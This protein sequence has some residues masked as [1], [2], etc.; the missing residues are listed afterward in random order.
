[1][2]YGQG[3]F[4]QFNTVLIPEL[5]EQG[6]MTT[7]LH[8]NHSEDHSEL[9]STY[10]DGAA[11]VVERRQVERLLQSCAGCAA[12]LADLRTVK[13]A[14]R[15]L[16]TPVP[17]RSFTL[18]PARAQP[19]PRLF[20][21]F[22]FASL[23]TAV[24]L[25]LVVGFD[26]LQTAGRRGMQTSV[27]APSSASG[28]PAGGATAGGEETYSSRSAA[29]GA[30]TLGGTDT[31]GIMQQSAPAET[32]AAAALAMP[33][34]ATAAAGAA[35]EGAT[36]AAAAPAAPPQ[37]AGAADKQAPTTAAGVAAPETTSASAASAAEGALAPTTVAGAAEAS[38][39]AEQP[40]EQPANSGGG[41]AGGAAG[42]APSAALRS[43]EN[44][45]AANTMT[46]G[47]GTS[48][49][50]PPARLNPLRIVEYALALLLLGL[51]LATWWTARR[52]I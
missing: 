9:L 25:V 41:T 23:I 46:L 42:G 24:L 50:P 34:A 31:A 48:P 33:Q 52:Q 15:A 44:S 28:G 14:L 1:M 3:N 38:P 27:S 10:L 26:G 8:H 49:A 32:A 36:T 22:R 6:I 12:D 30:D 21:V 2:R 43:S 39:H 18:D 17:R 11:S 35:Q 13:A 37:P 20:P 7:S 29:G 51:A 4:Y 16:P 19:R 5:N 40:V 47:P 45:G